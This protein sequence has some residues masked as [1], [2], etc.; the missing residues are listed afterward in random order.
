M[1]TL[2]PEGWPEKPRQDWNTGDKLKCVI[3]PAVVGVI[4]LIMWAIWKL[5]G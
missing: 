1:P 4:T 2:T 5:T 3:I